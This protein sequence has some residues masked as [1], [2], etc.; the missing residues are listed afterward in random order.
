MT[1]K[2]LIKP[3]RMRTAGVVTAPSENGLALAYNQALAAVLDLLPDPELAKVAVR[4]R[5]Q[6]RCRP[7]S[8]NPDQTDLALLKVEAEACRRW[9]IQGGG[10]KWLVCVLS[11]ELC[12]PREEA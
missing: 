6:L 2:T 8:S 10:N 5:Y 4:L 1:S 12:V 9:N 3:E 7:S 11:D